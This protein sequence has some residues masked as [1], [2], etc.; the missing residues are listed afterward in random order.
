MSSDLQY[1]WHFLYTLIRTF[2]F[3]APWQKQ[4]IY[5]NWKSKSLDITNSN[6]IYQGRISTCVSNSD[7]PVLARLLRLS[8]DIFLRPKGLGNGFWVEEVC[9]GIIQRSCHK[10]CRLKLNS[11]QCNTKHEYIPAT[12]LMFQVIINS[13]EWMTNNNTLMV[14]FC[15]YLL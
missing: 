10:A 12:A 11:Y 4:T 13:T 3:K 6:M 2:E 7:N 1:Q 15:V 5:R 9:E 14:L 8:I